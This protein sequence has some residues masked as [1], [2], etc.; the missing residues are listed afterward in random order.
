MLWRWIVIASVL[1][2]S[3]GISFYFRLFPK[4]PQWFADNS[5]LKNLTDFISAAI[6]LGGVIVAIVRW[7]SARRQTP[8]P[9]QGVIRNNVI[10]G[11]GNKLQQAAQGAISSN[12]IKGDDNRL[13]SSTNQITDNSIVGNENELGEG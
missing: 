4:L 10:R 12:R 8:P 13:R 2:P 11:S 3:I 1:L 5:W 9:A 6:V 7:A